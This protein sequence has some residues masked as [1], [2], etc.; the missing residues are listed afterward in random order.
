M[1]SYDTHT[2]TR[3][4]HIHSCTQKSRSKIG[5]LPSKCYFPKLNLHKIRRLQFVAILKICVCEFSCCTYL[6]AG[7]RNSQLHVP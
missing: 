4:A 5:H 1:T 6:F 2:R 7:R 3:D